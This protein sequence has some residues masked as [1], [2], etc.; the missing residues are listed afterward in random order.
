MKFLMSG[1][2]IIQLFL[3]YARNNRKNLNF[4]ILKNNYR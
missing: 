1:L 3:S 2:D 4:Q